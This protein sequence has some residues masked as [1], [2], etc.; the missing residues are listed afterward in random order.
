VRRGFVGDMGAVVVVV[1]KGLA[2]RWLRGLDEAHG[3]GAE[4]GGERGER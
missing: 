2:V 4:G 1:V 3:F